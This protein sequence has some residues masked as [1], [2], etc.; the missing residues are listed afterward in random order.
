RINAALLTAVAAIE[1]E[2]HIQPTQQEE[3]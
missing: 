1:S 3:N 2:M